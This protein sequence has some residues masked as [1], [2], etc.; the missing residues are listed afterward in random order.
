MEYSKSLPACQTIGRGFIVAP[1]D[2]LRKNS[3]VCGVQ[4]VFSFFMEEL[5]SQV[6][7]FV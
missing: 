7:C 2:V 1:I 4:T 6:Y 3:I 5:F